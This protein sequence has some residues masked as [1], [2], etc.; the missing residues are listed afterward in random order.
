[1]IFPL[2]PPFIEDCPIATFHWRRK[3]HTGCTSASASSCGLL[4]VNSASTDRTKST[5]QIRP[6]RRWGILASPYELGLSRRLRARC[7][8]GTS[9][10]R[11]E[12]P[13][14]IPEE[15]VFSNHVPWKIFRVP[16]DCKCSTEAILRRMQH[17]N[18]AKECR[19]KHR[20]WVYQHKMSN[21]M[22]LNKTLENFGWA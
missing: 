8:W 22:G 13:T 15:N 1:M 10:T 5:W 2:R 12:T 21:K 18:R 16:D 7:W 17:Q 6:G 9:E 19:S 20:T 11:L 4:A 14:S 3:N